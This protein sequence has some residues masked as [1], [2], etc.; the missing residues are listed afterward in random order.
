VTENFQGMVNEALVL[1]NCRG[2]MEC[3]RKLAHQHQ[4]GNSS[5][6]HVATPSA[7]PM[8]HHDQPQ[9]QPKQHVARQGFSTPQHQVIQCPNNFQNH[10]T[11]NQSVQMT[12]A[13]HN[14]LQGEQKCYA[15]GERGHYANQCPNPRARPPQTTKGAANRVKVNQMDAIQGSE[16]PVVNEFANVFPDEL[17]G[18]PHDRDIEFVIELK[19]STAHIYKTPYRMTTSELAELKENLK[20]LLVKGFI[21]PSSSPWGTP[22]IFVLKKD[23]TQRL[24]VDYHA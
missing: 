5:R 6:P 9:F 23:G 24:C 19:P 8:F 7:G 15:C 18:M 4:P 2:V 13:T 16:V 20:E 14:P 10:A 1:E 3:K 12:Q 11:R 17:P 21:L 22:V